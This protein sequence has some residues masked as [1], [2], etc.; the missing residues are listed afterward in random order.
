MSTFN[1][2]STMQIAFV[3]LYF[4]ID[5]VAVQYQQIV[6]LSWRREILP[7]MTQIMVNVLTV[8]A[9]LTEAVH[10][11]VAI[12]V[13]LDTAGTRNP[14]AGTYPVYHRILNVAVMGPAVPK[15]DVMD[16]S[17]GL[18]R[19]HMI[20]HISLNIAILSI[21]TGYDCHLPGTT[22]TDTFL[23]TT[24]TVSDIYCDSI[25]SSSSSTT[26][27]TSTST[28][29]ESALAAATAE[30]SQHNGMTR[31]IEFRWFLLLGGLATGFLVALA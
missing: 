25:S 10:L 8:S 12:A 29:S 16:M 7:A 2:L 30:S 17:G 1:L 21:V 13:V 4:T 18:G 26:S 23:G 27:T 9:A 6:I 5:L 3:F 19:I 31:T 15:V 28:S 24:Y 11:L 14:A 22:Y 20:L